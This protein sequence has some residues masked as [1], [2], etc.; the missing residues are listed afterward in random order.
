M[1][2]DDGKVAYFDFSDPAQYHSFIRTRTD[3]NSGN[4]GEIDDV[5]IRYLTEK[6]IPVTERLNRID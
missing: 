5:T 6:N 4:S 1:E 2:F 3:Y